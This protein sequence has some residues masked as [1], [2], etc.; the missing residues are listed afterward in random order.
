MKRY[1]EKHLFFS[2]FSS[3]FCRFADRWV[4]S[5][6]EG[7]VEGGPP[8]RPQLARLQERENDRERELGERERPIYE[9][10]REE[11]ALLGLLLL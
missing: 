6:T 3:C 5:V 2:V 11:A 10:V 9:D 7:G 1:L 4:W 8:P